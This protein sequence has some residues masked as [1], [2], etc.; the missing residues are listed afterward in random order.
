M[1][2]SYFQMAK[3]SLVGWTGL[4]KDALHIHV[5]LVVF[6]AAALLFRWPLRSWKPWAVALAVT[7]AG[8]VWDLWDALDEG[9]RI[10]FRG[11]W[12]DVWNTMLW[13]TAI[14]LL[15]RSTRL[16]GAGRR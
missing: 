6:F 13:P 11:N 10:Q 14:L 15:A 2:G 12:K 7:L 3:L 8:E 16:L 1:K 9:W 4:A 5:G